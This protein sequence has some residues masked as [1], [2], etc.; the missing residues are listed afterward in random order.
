MNG[1]LIRTDPSKIANKKRCTKS[2][3]LIVVGYTIFRFRA[4]LNPQKWG[5][6]SAEACLFLAGN[7][8]VIEINVHLIPPR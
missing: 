2:E 1:E 4:T 8:G 5:K 3:R 6:N 7:G